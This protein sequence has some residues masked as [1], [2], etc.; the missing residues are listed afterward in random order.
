MRHIS[1]TAQIQPQSTSRILMIRPTQFGFNQQT[2]DSNVFQHQQAGQRTQEEIS[3]LAQAE[4]DLMV[5]QLQMAGVEVKVIDELEGDRN[6]DAVFSNN[7]ISYHQSGRVVL[8]PMLAENRRSE[9]RLDIVEQLRSDYHIEEV[10]DLTHFEKD[11]KFLEGTGSMVL[12]RRYKIAYACLSQRTHLEVLQ[13]FAEKLDYEVVYFHA[14]DDLG[15]PIYHTNVMMCIG[16]IFAVICLEAIHNPDERQRVRQTLE[17]TNKY[18]IELSLEQI[19]HFAGNMLMVRNRRQEKFLVM[20][21]AAY[22]ILT[23]RQRSILNDYARILHTDLSIIERYG[24]G[25]ARCML[26]EN[27]LPRS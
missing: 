27:H 22:D 10:I 16:D 3:T 15:R 2:A 17:Q 19:K 6:P 9:R 11:G 5:S 26:T 18:L 7:W 21:T 12:D 23:D 24:G 20:S 8:Y 4:F 13:A 25:S 14:T 1:S